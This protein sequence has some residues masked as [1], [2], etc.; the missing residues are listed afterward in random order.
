MA[1]IT[2]LNQTS[3]DQLRRIIEDNRITI[4]KTDSTR[5]QIIC[6]ECD[7]PEAYI[8]FNQ[9]SRVIQCN[10]QENCN[11][12][13]SLWDYIVDRRGYS[14]KNMTGYINQLLGYEFKDFTNGRERSFTN[15]NYVH[16]EQKTPELLEKV[17]TDKPI[18]TQEEI[19][20]EQEFFKHCHQIFTNCLQ[21][22]DNE[23]VA[24][25]L[26]YLKEDR[27]YDD[28]QIISFK[29]GFF[30]D[31]EKFILLLTNVGYLKEVGK[32]LIEQ[33]FLGILN[34]NKYKK[35]DEETKNRITFTWFNHDGNIAGFTIRKPTDKEG[36]EARY[37]NN[38]GLGKA[39]HLYNLTAEAKNKKIV[40]VEGQLDALAGTYFTLPQEEIKNYHFV[41]I[42]G[43]NISERQ[44]ACL[45][46]LNC[47]KVI[48]LLDN[49]EAGRKGAIQTAEKL[50]AAGISPDIANIPKECECK[51]IDELIRKYKEDIDGEYPDLKEI[52]DNAPKYEIAVNPD[53]PIKETQME[54]TK[55]EIPKLDPELQ[56]LMDKIKST[57]IEQDGTTKEIKLRPLEVFNYAKDIS[58]IR[59]RLVGQTIGSDRKNDP[60]FIALNNIY[61][62]IREYNNLLSSDETED[63]PYTGEQLLEEVLK[64]TN[65]GL[66]TGFKEVDKDIT[67]QPSSLAFIAGRP[68]HGKTTMMLNMLRNMLEDEDKKENKNK[69]AFLFYS[70]E[71]TRS[72]ILIKIILSVADEGLNQE[73]INA[74]VEGGN[75]RQRALNNLKN[76][77]LCVKENARGQLS[78]LNSKLGIAYNK[79]N[80]WI[81]EGRLEILTAKSNVESLSTAIFERCTAFKEAE[82]NEDNNQAEQIA[83]QA[84]GIQTKKKVAAVFIDYVQK[85]TTEEERVNRQQEIQK[86]C[87]TLLSTALDKSVGTSIILGAQVNRNVT[88]LEELTLD[89]MREAGD[90]EQDANLVLGIW[91]DQ[92]G[93]ID[94]LV[95]RLG[96]LKDKLK[97]LELGIDDLTESNKP[98]KPLSKTKINNVIEQIK[99]DL[100]A[101]QTSLNT[102][103][104]KVLKNR[105]GQNN[106]LFK[107][108]GYLDRYF[109]DDVPKE[110]QESPVAK[111]RKELNNQRT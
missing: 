67:I 98:K 32:K 49:D 101:E 64:N 105:N 72:D 38:K 16:K 2:N 50:I 6:P 35:T 10:R 103:M 86:I 52:L 9:G 23:Q 26:R 41:A 43:N 75:L 36:I 4:K 95:A 68:S 90:I 15:A 80:A 56:A 13:K 59:A 99:N 109:I 42:S 45:K 108:R 17:T 11:F 20:E 66:K 81:K 61:S 34:I 29:L 58:A 1:T 70:Y 74:K 31:E 18:R 77:P 40:I 3:P 89:K 19:A 33:Y 102:I 21:E 83:E 57:G 93:E 24:F 78:A 92:A 8:Y 47:R 62:H 44:V 7:K 87:Q 97:R 12:S 22:Q 88:S 107:L 84:K 94:W 82:F 5:Y 27:G 100:R 91:N 53:K 71:E 30:P 54:Q 111:A 85:L 60:N 79:V 69:K 76:Y 46:E 39:D 37:V 51:D 96:E 25:S 110:E 14:N 104:V 106:G 73:L 48:L 63:K 65:H 55:Q 28:K